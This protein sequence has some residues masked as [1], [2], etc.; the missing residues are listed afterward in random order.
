MPTEHETIIPRT[1]LSFFIKGQI[2]NQSVSITGAYP[3]KPWF[4][5]SGFVHQGV[6]MPVCDPL[7]GLHLSPPHKH[8]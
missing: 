3:Q 1:E 6:T 2:I 4:A 7:N 5:V 8:S